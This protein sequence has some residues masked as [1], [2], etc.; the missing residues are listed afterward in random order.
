MDRVFKSLDSYIDLHPYYEKAG[1]P[2]LSIVKVNG[3]KICRLG[4]YAA[5]HY[6]NQDVYDSAFAR[7][8]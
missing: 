4:G 3:T 1:G 6:Y 8:T 2:T 7:Q 5:A